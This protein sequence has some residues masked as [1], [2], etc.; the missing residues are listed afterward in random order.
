MVRGKGSSRHVVKRERG[1]MEDTTL[2][3]LRSWGVLDAKRS[4]S[5]KGWLSQLLPWKT[6]MLFTANRK[7]EGRTVWNR[8]MSELVGFKGL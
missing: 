4:G 1:R 3:R 2:N 5:W 8:V 6:M 7:G